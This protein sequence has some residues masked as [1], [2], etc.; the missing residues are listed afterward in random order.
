[1]KYTQNN[2]TNQKI[3]HRP[4]S[5]R[6]NFLNIILMSINRIVFI[7]KGT[8]IRL[9]FRSSAIS[10]VCAIWLVMPFRFGEVKICL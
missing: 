8:N 3:F 7:L 2:E 9:E 5:R 10:R 6:N 1:M 4:D